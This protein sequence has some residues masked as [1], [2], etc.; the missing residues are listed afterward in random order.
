MTKKDYEYFENS[1]KRQICGNTYVDGDVTVR[2]H[3]HITRKYRGSACRYFNIKVKLN[4]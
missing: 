2:D 1:T 4:C 3:C